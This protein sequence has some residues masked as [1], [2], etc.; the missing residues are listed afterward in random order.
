MNKYT[1]LLIII[2]ANSCTV[3]PEYNSEWAQ[4][5]CSRI[6]SFRADEGGF[7]NCT[8]LPSRKAVCNY[9]NGDS[10]IGF[11]KD[12]ELHG[13]G[14]YIWN[15][16]TTFNG[17]WKDGDKWCGIQKKGNLF[18][19]YKNGNESKASEAGI[20]WEKVAVGMI[21]AAAVYAIAESSSGA[22][23]YYTYDWDGFYDQYGNWVYRCRT[24]EN[25]QFAADYNCSS[26]RK[27]DDRWP[28]TY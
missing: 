11:L 5:N 14:K 27:D 7:S 25:G 10:Y 16:S 18:T 28:S 21:A 19:T 3:M 20:E 26:K 23:S 13:T 2:L 8:Y 4:I 9:T 6:P 12:N 22:G 24:I 15:D 17:T 1:F